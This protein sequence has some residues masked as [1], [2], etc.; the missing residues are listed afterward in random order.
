MGQP[1]FV[2]AAALAGPEGTTRTSVTGR[3]VRT[4][5]AQLS[6]SAITGE[7]DLPEPELR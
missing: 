3:A 5:Q 7:R 4:G 1:S 2:R 6:L